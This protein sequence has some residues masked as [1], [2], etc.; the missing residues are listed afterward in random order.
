M[1]APA[2][3][4]P[5]YLDMITNAIKALAEKSGSSRQAVNKYIVR[6]YKL[7]E[8]NHHRAML[9]KALKSGSG[10]KGP[11]VHN[12]GK[13][14]AGSFKL[15][16]VAAKPK[17]AAKKPVKKPAAKKSP[18]SKTPAKKPAKPAAPATSAPTAAKKPAG[19]VKAKG[20][21]AKVV[22]KAA[23]PKK[24]KVVKAKKPT[25]KKSPKSAKKPAGKK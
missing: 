7:T 14:A 13:G 3:S 5:K 12:K 17:T 22:K 15:R 21:K 11:L 2:A 24:P 23:Q 1:P 18:K 8:N 6:E 9:N 19:P 10:P 25:A 16:P 4:H 20:A